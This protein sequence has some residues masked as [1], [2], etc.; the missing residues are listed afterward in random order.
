MPQTP[1]LLLV[2]WSLSGT[3]NA[4]YDR[5]KKKTTWSWQACVVLKF[6]TWVTNLYLNFNPKFQHQ[7]KNSHVKLQGYH[8][9]FSHSAKM[10]KWYPGLKMLQIIRIIFL[11][12]ILIANQ[13]AYSWNE[14]IIII[15]LAFCQKSNYLIMDKM[16]VKFFYNF[17]HHHLISLL[18]SPQLLRKKREETWT[19]KALG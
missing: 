6:T 7:F 18:T 10:L 8:G 12:M 4:K 14:R 13:M 9:N 19:N 3:F 11:P 1:N 5:Q 17:A 2:M 15:P 16:H